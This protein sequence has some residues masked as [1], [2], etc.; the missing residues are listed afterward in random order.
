MLRCCCTFLSSIPCII[1]NVQKK[2][3]LVE[4]FEKIPA[5]ETGFTTAFR[6]SKQGR[7]FA[8]V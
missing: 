3:R 4:D 6:V 8:L 1:V 5:V 2:R 7:E